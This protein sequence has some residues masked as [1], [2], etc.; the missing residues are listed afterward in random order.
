MLLMGLGSFLVSANETAG[1][2]AAASPAAASVRAIGGPSLRRLTI[3][4]VVEDRT[5]RAVGQR[6]DL[7]GA[8]CRCFETL[9]AE[10]TDQAHD[11]ETGAEALFGVG[12]A[13]QDLFAQRRRRG[14]DRSGFVANALDGPVGVNPPRAARGT[15]S[16][17]SQGIA[18]RGLLLCRMAAANGSA[19]IIMST[20]RLTSTASPTAC[21]SRGRGPADAAHRR[22]LSQ[23][24]ADRRASA[25]QRQSSA[26]HRRRSH[27]V[28]PPALTPRRRIS[29]SSLMSCRSISPIVALSSARL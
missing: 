12:P 26:H 5:H 27:A 6:A 4:L 9:G 10:R 28:E 23:G 18:R 25:F 13:L 11:A 3:E 24:R 14:A 29:R 19:S 16:A 2:S 20:S 1:G 21:P 22:G 17:A 7:D 8:R 15:R